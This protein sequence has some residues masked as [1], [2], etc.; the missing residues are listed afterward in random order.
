MVEV[1]Q[2][3]PDAAFDMA[4]GMRAKIADWRGQKLVVYFY[5]KDDTGGCTK[6]AQALTALMPLAKSENVTVP[7]SAATTR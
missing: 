4:D 5:P 6:E 3:A 1:G 7:L 2:M